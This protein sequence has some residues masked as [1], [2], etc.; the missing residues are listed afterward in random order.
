V[1]NNY[2]LNIWYEASSGTHYPEVECEFMDNWWETLRSI[3]SNPVFR[4]H[5][6]DP[7]EIHIKRQ[8]IESKLLQ[9]MY[10]EV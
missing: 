3:V 5:P 9:V 7:G 2:K 6:I 10:G 8:T 4:R 1:Y